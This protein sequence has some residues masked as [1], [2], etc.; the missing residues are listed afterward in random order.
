[1][2]P[3]LP[4]C[5]FFSNEECEISRGDL[6]SN[7]TSQREKLP[8]LPPGVGRL[9]QKDTKRALTNHGPG[10]DKALFQRFFVRNLLSRI[11]YQDCS[12]KSRNSRL[13]EA[14]VLKGQHKIWIL[15]VVALVHFRPEFC[16]WP[17]DSTAA[18]ASRMREFSAQF[19]VSSIKYA[20]KYTI[21][22][23]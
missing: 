5:I 12:R 23:S 7:F 13:F 3:I 11:C 4:A 8:I 20:Q 21:C 15:P 1:M 18:A 14:H 17:M 6:W 22:S 16:P 19:L 9:E 10:D 2:I